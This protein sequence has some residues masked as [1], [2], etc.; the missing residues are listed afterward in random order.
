MKT[1]LK[2]MFIALAAALAAAQPF[3][4]EPQ[5]GIAKL[6][7]VHGNV[8][9][10]RDTGLAAGSNAMRLMDGM[11][12]ITT[13]NSGVVVEYDNGCRVELKEN[14]RTVV[15][16]DKP[17]E[18]LLLAVESVVQPAAAVAASGFGLVTP[19]AIVPV[20][21]LGVAINE[22]NHGGPPTPPAVSPN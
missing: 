5:G 10:S 20:A 17:C 2:S 15:Q 22:W 14:Q 1:Y 18:A 21:V 8:L 16:R 4:Q 12:V 9:V 7:D 13:S 6:A 3:A 11:R 19:Y